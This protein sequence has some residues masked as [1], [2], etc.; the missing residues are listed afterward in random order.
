MIAL[1]LALLGLWHPAALLAG[2]PGRVT[3][4]FDGRHTWT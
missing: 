3:L 2:R 4:R 1:A